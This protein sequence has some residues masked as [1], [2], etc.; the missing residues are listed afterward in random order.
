M[1]FG[2]SVSERRP[3]SSLQNRGDALFYRLYFMN[4]YSGHTEIWADVEAADDHAGLAQAMAHKG[5]RHIELWLGSR[6]V[7]RVD[8]ARPS[9]Q[10]HERHMSGSG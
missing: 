8:A 4:E 2:L 5:K 1:P 3:S 6:K 9:P 10:F 7:G